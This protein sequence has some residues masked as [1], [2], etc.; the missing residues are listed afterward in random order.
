MASSGTLKTSHF[1]FN[2]TFQ[3]TKLFIKHLDLKDRQKIYKKINATE[4]NNARKFIFLHK[5]ELQSH[6][7]FTGF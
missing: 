1:R 7:L 5:Y 4:Y 3:G 6:Q 2:G